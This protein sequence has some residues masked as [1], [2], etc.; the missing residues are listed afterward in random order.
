MINGC[1]AQTAVIAKRCC[2][3]VKSGPF[4]DLPSFDLDGS[5]APNTGRCWRARGRFR[6]GTY[7]G[8]SPISKPDGTDRDP[9]R[10]RGT[11]GRAQCPPTGAV[12]HSPKLSS[13]RATWGLRASQV[14]VPAKRLVAEV[15][16][17]TDA[18]EF[19]CLPLAGGIRLDG[20]R[21]V[22]RSATRSRLAGRSRRSD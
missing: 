22:G 13:N 12:C 4:A 10:L 6:D 2:E 7:R 1:C 21:R 14:T 3:R 5:S 9:R 17:R 8:T 11:G 20:S 16:R 18:V 15:G 19:R